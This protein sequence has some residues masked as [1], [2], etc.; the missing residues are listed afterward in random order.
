MEK[1]R[2]VPGRASKGMIIG[3]AWPCARHDHRNHVSRPDIASY[4]LATTR[5]PMECTALSTDSH[6][7]AKVAPMQPD[8]SGP[9]SAEYITRS[10]ISD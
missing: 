3:F 2:L 10:C 6:L 8:T 4:I 9:H 5:K 7:C 1:G